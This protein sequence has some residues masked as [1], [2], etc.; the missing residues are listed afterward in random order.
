MMLALWPVYLLAAGR[1]RE[2]LALDHVVGEAMLDAAVCVFDVLADDR[3]IQVDARL[4]EDGLHARECLEDAEVGVRAEELAKRHIDRLA[5][6]AL[7]RFHRALEH[8][9]AVLDGA[10]GF[11]GD[12]LGV[13]LVE[14]GFAHLHGNEV[15]VVV[16]LGSL[17]QTH[18]RVHDLRTDS[19]SGSKS[20]S[21]TQRHES[22]SVWV[23][24][25]R[26][27]EG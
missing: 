25:E 15:H 22:V 6:A 18:C 19:I 21:D 12:A 23:I 13:A 4:G 10:D 26:G 14:D 5:A 2:P 1:G 8:H 7:G 11:I 20:N 9:A 16:H 24:G 27:K 3:E 17:E